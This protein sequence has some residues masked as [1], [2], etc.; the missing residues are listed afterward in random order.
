M[1]AM[2]PM[3]MIKL[4]STDA[5]QMIMK[6]AY[7]LLGSDG[8]VASGHGGTMNKTIVLERSAELS[9]F[10]GPAIA[11]GASNIQRNIIGER[12]LGLPRDPKAERLVFGIR[13][14]C[15]GRERVALI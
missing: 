3:M 13:N 14:E 7:D 5:T 11:G 6:A 10:L 2:L 9:F 12:G 15:L 4:F 8:L 1:Q